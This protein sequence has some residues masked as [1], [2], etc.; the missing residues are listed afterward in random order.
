MPHHQ[1]ADEGGNVQAV[2]V[3]V[4]EDA[5]FAVA[6]AAQVVAGRVNADGNGDV[7]DFLRAHDDGG[8]VFPGVFDFAAQ[9]HDGLILTVACLFGRAAR[10]VTLDQ[11]EL[12][13]AVVLADAVGEFAG[14]RRTAG[15]AFA[16]DLFV[17]VEAFLRMADGERGESLADVGVF[18][19]V[20]A[21]VVFD[22]VA[23]PGG[24]LARG[25][26]FFGL[27]GELGFD[28]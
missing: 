12:G 27:A 10:R 13:Q 7:V 16:G 23:N 11:E 18:V 6:Q 15:R 17:A 25:E 1:G 21:E 2:R 24:A 8:V 14:Q 5:D 4:G 3:G 9:G 20:E 19:E 28:F 22:G 26:A